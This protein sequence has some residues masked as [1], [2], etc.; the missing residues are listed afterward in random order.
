MAF[1]NVLLVVILIGVV[2]FGAQKLP[3]LARALGKA[4][5]EFEKGKRES[6]RETSTED[7][8]GMSKQDE[9]TSEP[10]TDNDIR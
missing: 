8:R 3:E 9:L 2:L 7:T 6:I 10:T 1:E 5:S 4:Q